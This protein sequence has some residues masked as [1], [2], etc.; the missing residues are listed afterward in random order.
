M[1]TKKTFCK[2]PAKLCLFF[3]AAPFG[4][5]VEETGGWTSNYVDGASI[6]DTKITGTDQRTW[7]KKC[8]L[9]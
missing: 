6:R 4:F 5:L 2:S 3:E 8:K 7:S 9:A 1:N